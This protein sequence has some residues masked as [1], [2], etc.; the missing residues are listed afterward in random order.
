MAATIPRMSLMEGL[1]SRS[2]G[3]VA[4]DTSGVVL[5]LANLI[6]LAGVLFWDWDIFNIVVLYW[7]ENV[8]I[9]GINILKMLTCAPDMKAIAG[10]ADELTGMSSGQ[11]RKIREFLNTHGD[12]AGL[13]HHGSKFFFIPFFTVHYG[14]FCLVHGVFVFVLLGGSARSGGFMGGATP[15]DQFPALIRGALDAGGILAALAL[16]AS[17]LF[18]FF[19]NYLGKGE[20]RRTVLPELMGAPYGRVVV[21]HLAI[22]FGAFAT[23]ILG[24]PVI[25]LLLLIAG[26]I[27]LDLKLH[28]RSHRKP[29]A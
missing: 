21:L 26:K 2:E 10:R 11:S 20:Y 16:V 14:I 29:T 4:R 25:L 6:P 28:H 23:F 17:H 24:S 8:I 15:P 7:F 22:L 18:S 9:G 3:R 19:R 13:L 12:K 5:I 1:R 27:V